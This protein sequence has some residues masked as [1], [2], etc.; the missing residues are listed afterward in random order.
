VKRW[1]ATLL[2]LVLSPVWATVGAQD[3]PDYPPPDYPQ[4]EPEAPPTEPE[5]P[6]EGPGGVPPEAQQDYPYDDPTDPAPSPD[7]YEEALRPYGSWQ[8]DPGYGRFWRPG[9]PSGWQ[10]YLDGRWAWTP[11]GWTW[12]SYEPWS[13]TFHYGRWSYLPAWGWSWF[14]GSTWGPAWVRWSTYG[15]YVGWA[16]LSPFGRL[17]F[18]R[19]VF[20]RDYDFCAPHL[21]Y[22]HFP[23]NRVPWKVRKH[24]RDHPRWPDRRQIE[25][26]S[27]H[28]VHV[29]PDRPR[30]SLAPWQRERD[31]HPGRPVGDQVDRG[32]DQRRPREDRPPRRWQPD[33]SPGGR[34]EPDRSPPRGR[35]DPDRSP[36]RQT[37]VPDAPP[38]RDRQPPA[39]SGLRGEE[40]PRPERAERPW[41]LGPRGERPSGVR[42]GPRDNRPGGDQRWMTRDRGA[43]P[44]GDAGRLPDRGGAR[45]AGGRGRGGGGGHGRSG[46]GSGWSRGGGGGSMFSR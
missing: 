35:D 7:Q 4:T 37:F 38:E 44:R 29:L 26:V 10:P 15:G 20:V 46:Q 33:R 23:W 30:E 24:W 8:A 6:P 39:R 14:P 18:N 21:R 32:D 36:P 45:D 40:R 17:G 43:S 16:P 25:R 19:Y 28:P 3:Y 9:V 34:W 41:S 5:A 42:P 31:R 27:R 12:G 2:V 1:P 13:W 22:R 11:Y